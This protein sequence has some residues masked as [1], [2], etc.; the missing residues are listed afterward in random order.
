MPTVMTVKRLL[1]ARRNVKWSPQKLACVNL[2]S[3]DDCAG[4]VGVCA[5]AR[6]CFW[7]STD[8]GKQAQATLH[9][10]A[11]RKVGG[12]GGALIND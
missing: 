9:L 6:L 5:S 10:V 12:G 1:V 8:I 7:V 2:W 3:T 4:G 11:C